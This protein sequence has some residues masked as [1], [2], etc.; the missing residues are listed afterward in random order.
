[1][2]FLHSRPTNVRWSEEGQGAGFRGQEKEVQSSKVQ[3]FKV[4]EKE[5]QSSK[6]QKLKT[7]K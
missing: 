5:V 2:L 4:E 6:V 1:M 3:K 7:K